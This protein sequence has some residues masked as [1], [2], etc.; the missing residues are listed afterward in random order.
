MTKG[1]DLGQTHGIVQRGGMWDIEPQCGEEAFNGV[2]IRGKSSV[3]R[4]FSWVVTNAISAIK[5]MLLLTSTPGPFPLCS[6]PAT[7][8]QPGAAGVV[9]AQGQ[10]PAL[11][12]V[13]P[14]TIGLS[15]WIQPVLIPLQ[16]LPALQQINTP[17]QLG[18]I[19]KMAEGAL[20]SLI[21]IINK[22]ITQGLTL[23]L[24]DTTSD[25]LPIGF[26]FTHHHFL[27]YHP[28]FCLLKSTDIHAMSSQF[29]PGDAV[30]NGVKGFA[31]V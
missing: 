13:E 6:F 14:H 28:V 26:N 31:E 21:Q 1:C 17:T 15:P 25:W 24:G 30:R 18:A 3:Q 8:S 11:D 16:S 23:I 27:D 4:D 2:T 29:F 22:D 10:D 9:V 12:L 19:C 20:D 5:N 7:L